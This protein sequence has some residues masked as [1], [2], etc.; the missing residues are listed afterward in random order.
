MSRLVLNQSIKSCFTKIAYPNGTVRAI[1]MRNII[2]VNKEDNNKIRIEYNFPRAG[3]IGGS[4]VGFGAMWAD[5]DPHYEVIECAD[6]VAATEIF[7]RL[8]GDIL[9]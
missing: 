7:E 8:T 6:S 3:A 4:V 9:V 2:T 1:N 5:S